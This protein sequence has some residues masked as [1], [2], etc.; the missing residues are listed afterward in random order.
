MA[1]APRARLV[2]GA[3]PVGGADARLH[4]DARP[5]RSCAP[6]SPSCTQDLEPDDVYTFAGAE[7]AIFVAMHALLEPGDHA[8]VLWPGYQALYEVARSAG[9][10]VTLVAL[11]HD[12]GWALDL[13]EVAAAVR[14]GRTKLVVANFPHSPDG[15]AADLRRGARA[16]GDREP[17]GRPPVPRRG[18]SILGIRR[19]RQGTGGRRRG[20]H[21]AGRH[22]EGLRVGGSSHRVASLT[23]SRGARAVRA[24]QGLHDHLQQRARRRCSR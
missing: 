6:R 11:R 14:P 3:C 2:E 1:R 23:R 13:D 15:C 19:T 5:A 18:V 16:R 12:A 9:A 22:V 20:R 21:L 8:V 4:R 17:S 10:E 24:A 7:E